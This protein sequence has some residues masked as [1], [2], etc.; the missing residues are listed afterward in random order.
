MAAGQR[1]AAPR[2]AAGRRRASPALLRAGSLIAAAAALSAAVGAFAGVQR[3]GRVEPPRR[4]VAARAEGGWRSWQ[5]RLDKALLDVDA[6]PQARIKNLRKALQDPAAIAQD[7][8][9]AVGAV[10]EKGLRK[11]HPEALDALWPKGTTARADLEGIV[12][13]GKQ[14]P[15]ILQDFGNAQNPPFRGSGSQSNVDVGDLTAALPSLLD[16]A[17]REEL[18]DEAKNVF[19]RTP[20]G[21]EQPKY[22]VVRP[23]ADGAELRRY[24]PFSV[25]SRAMPDGRGK[26][27]SSAEGFTSLA[28]YLFGDNANKTAMAMTMPVEISFGTLDSSANMSFVLPKAYE[29]SA[30]L[31]NDA[32]VQLVDVPERLVAVR[33]FAG[34]A[35]A[36]EVE[37]QRQ[38]LE[39][40][41]AADEQELRPVDDSAYSVLQYNPPYTLPWRRRNELAVVVEEE[42]RAEEPAAEPAELEAEVLAGEAAGGD[43]V[44]AE[45]AGSR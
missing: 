26:A 5:R 7:L 39:K 30:P 40:A 44:A 6:P 21:L 2:A 41:L 22:A 43:S 32:S 15:E 12:A 38:K 45:A 11:G 25:A 35:T 10:A 13:L 24:Q 20:R 36:G 23:L 37:R 9:K 33:P 28:G 42:P 19:R 8:G 14:L 1:L 29:G 17:K 4:S 3:P 16:P 31:P 27:Y 18:A 34:V